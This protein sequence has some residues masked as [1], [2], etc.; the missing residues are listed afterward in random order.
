MTTCYAKRAFQTLQEESIGKISKKF[1]NIVLWKLSNKDN[2]IHFNSF[3]NV[4][5]NKV[6]YDAPK[7]PF[8]TILIDSNKIK[9]SMKYDNQGKWVVDPPKYGGLGQVKNDDWDKTEYRREVDKL[10]IVN[11]LKERFNEGKNW[12]DTVYYNYLYDKHSRTNKYKERGYDSVEDYVISQCKNYD[13]LYSEIKDRGYQPN[14]RGKRRRPGSNL[15]M[16]D[17]LEVLIVIDR[18]GNIN[19]TEGYHRFAIARCLDLEIPAH[20]LCRH[21]N[22]QMIRDHVYNSED[23]EDYKEELQNHP[24]LQDLFTE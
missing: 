23:L 1:I 4:I 11:G 2:Q 18:Y 9:H 3:K 8:E 12:E 15:M 17:Q 5:F 10:W 19:F 20:V 7:S 13:S 22:W 16:R 24:D 21:K 14:H 6:K